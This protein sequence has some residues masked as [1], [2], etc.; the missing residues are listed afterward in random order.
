[1]KYNPESFDLEIFFKK[2]AKK[3]NKEEEKN[4]SRKRK[5]GN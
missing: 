3:K 4:G 2:I 5:R 1:M